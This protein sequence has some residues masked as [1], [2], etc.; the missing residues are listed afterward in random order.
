MR[1]VTDEEFNKAWGNQEYQKIINKA[2]YLYRIPTLELQSCKMMG[3]WK[4][5]G[6]YNRKSKFSTFLF[7]QI[8]FQCLKWIKKFSKEIILPYVDS[9]VNPIVS[10]DINCVLKYLDAESQILIQER[11]IQGK[12][13]RELGLM[14]EVSHETIRKRLKKIISY[15]KMCDLEGLSV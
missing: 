5:L 11:F 7:N 2:S 6:E 14:Y 12:T 9:S 1:K 13:L 8:R 10:L 4:A 15:L 3:L